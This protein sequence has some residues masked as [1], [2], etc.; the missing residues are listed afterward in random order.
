MLNNTALCSERGSSEAVLYG[1]M[2]E[3]QNK[4]RIWPLVG[5]Y[6]E[7]KLWLIEAFNVFKINIKTA[8]MIWMILGGIALRVV[9]T[10]KGPVMEIFGWSVQSSNTS[11]IM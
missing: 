3:Q 1:L 10:V 11:L 7:N 6:N 8:L 5:V 4:S 9:K 2:P